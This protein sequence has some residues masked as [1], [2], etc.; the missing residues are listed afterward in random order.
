MTDKTRNTTAPAAT[1]PT[2]LDSEALRLERLHAAAERLNVAQYGADLLP[3]LATLFQAI[4]Q[5][6]EADSLVARLAGVG[7]YLAQDWGNT[8]DCMREEAQEAMDAINGGAA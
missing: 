3:E 7:L 5:L 2:K 6:A 8:L 1:T 4:K